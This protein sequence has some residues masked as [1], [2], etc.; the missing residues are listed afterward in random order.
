MRTGLAVKVEVMCV[1]FMGT[2]TIGNVQ[3]VRATPDGH[4]GALFGK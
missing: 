2:E 4:R 3:S 1:L